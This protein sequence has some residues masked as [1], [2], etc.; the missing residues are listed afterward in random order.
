VK[1]VG[2]I[3][4][5]GPSSGGSFQWTKNILESLNSFSNN[6]ENKIIA[7][8]LNENGYDNIWNNYNN[9]KVVRLNA[10]YFFINKF[11]DR[12]VFKFPKT[13]LLFKYISPLNIFSIFYNIDL[14][15]FPT[16]LSATYYR[17]KFVFMF[18]DISH[19]YYPNF[20]E[21]GG[22]YGIRYREAIFS[23]GCLN[24][25][26]IIVESEELKKE[27]VKFYDTLESKIFVL[28]QTF[29]TSLKNS[30]V[31][32]VSN[33]VLPEKYIFYPAQLWEHKNHINLLKA[34]KLVRE[35]DNK[36][37]LV[38]T[39]FSKS[40]DNNI[41]RLISELGLNNYVHYLGYVKDYQVI[42]LYKKAF[43]LVMPTYF[44]PTNIP[45][46]EAFFYGC[47]A[48]ISNLPGV[49]EQAQDAAQYFD[50]NDPNDISINILSLNDFK[51]RHKMIKEGFRRSKE[52]SFNNYYNETF[53]N[54]LHST[55][56]FQN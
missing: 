24:A 22:V 49:Y 17:K 15:I 27:V 36:I 25:T 56:R 32:E 40:G 47:P 26:C 42:E 52:L 3:I 9:I 29:S 21:L 48:V 46:L 8:V 38:L 39:G 20:P 50:P 1:R 35:K 2:V 53:Q 12:I 33:I 13:S 55:L 30:E 5:H 10:L 23:N 37:E 41:F 34:L 16:I 6:S 45:T 7:F 54:I 14:M 44:G 43:A 18:C 31:N 51:L 4:S 19:K 11:I 28:Y